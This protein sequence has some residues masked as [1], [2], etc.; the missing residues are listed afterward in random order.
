M[1]STVASESEIGDLWYQLTEI[2]P[3]FNLSPTD[4]IPRRKVT[5]RLQAFLKHCCHKKH[6]FFSTLKSVE[7]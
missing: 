7:M 1:V 2:D 3:E 4:K 6:Y 5:K